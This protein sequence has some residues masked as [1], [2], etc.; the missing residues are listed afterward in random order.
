[1]T[2]FDPLSIEQKAKDGELKAA[3]LSGAV[4][5]SEFAHM[6]PDQMKG[7]RLRKRKEREKREAVEEHM[8]GATVKT[9]LDQRSL[10][11]PRCR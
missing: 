9:M 7:S 6:T 2:H 8:I 5:P 3:V 4:T 10:T 1:M 11:C